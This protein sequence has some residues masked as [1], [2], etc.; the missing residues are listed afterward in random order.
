M[1]AL[2]Y[3]RFGPL[4]ILIVILVFI[5]GATVSHADTNLLVPTDL[6]RGFDISEALVA[7]VSFAT[8]PGIQNANSTVDWSDDQPNIDLKRTSFEIGR[9]FGWR[10]RW[11]KLFGGIGLSHVF[12]NDPLKVQ[13]TDGDT[14]KGDPERDLYTARLSGGLAFQL[15]PHIR[16]TPYLSFILSELD[17]ETTVSG[18]ADL[19]NIP[20]KLKPFFEDFNTKATTVAG[21]LELNYD[22][23]FDRRRIE[24]FGRYTQNQRP[25]LELGV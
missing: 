25:P 13:N 11:F 23:W 2:A 12:M 10:S 6:D 16:V 8:T 19:S 7:L 22:R 20:P 17:S 4:F 24:L 5:P 15:T 1:M 9:R 3:N 21:T 18:N 14:V